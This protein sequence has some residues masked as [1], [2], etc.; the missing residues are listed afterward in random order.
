MDFQISESVG[1]GHPDKIA[2]NISDSLLELI[3]KYD[4][5]AQFA[6]ETLVSNGLVVV[7]GEI[8][9]SDKSLWLNINSIFKKCIFEILSS[10]GYSPEDFEVI[11]NVNEQS[12]DIRNG[13]HLNNESFG[14]FSGD[15]SIVFGYASNETKSFLPISFAVATDLLRNIVENKMSGNI[16]EA[17][18]DMKSLVIMNGLSEVEKI[19]VS[20]HHL[21]NI[22]LVAFRK[23]IYKF[24]VLPVINKYGLFV[25]EENVFINYGGNFISGGLDADTGATNRKLLVDSYGP[26]VRHG[27]GGYSGKDL[28]KVD[29]LGAYYARW[30]CKNL[31]ASGVCD[32]AELE[33]TYGFGGSEA[34]NYLFRFK[35]P[36]YE[37]E[38][39]V[40]AV[41]KI[42]YL[43][44][45]EI[46]RA[47]NKKNIRYSILS[48]YGHFGRED[49][50]FPWEN[51]NKV[52]EIKKYFGISD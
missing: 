3:L 9:L 14:I 4:I 2:D 48:C 10:L 33:L 23:L 7:A 31:V 34:F 18:L 30:I 1:P 51:L 45:D 17:N 43:K 27:G 24:A 25:R 46:Y 49:E 37:Y 11:I 44:F 19:F 20:V 35:A 47:F 40:K 26:S 22:D 42:F 41:K 39:I 5:E 50:N 6:C 21:E 28:T 32:S 12:Q 16:V 36:K 52:L 13:S 8:F 38:D 29:R 15:Q